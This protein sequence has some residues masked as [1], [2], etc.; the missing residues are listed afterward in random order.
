MSVGP[1]LCAFDGAAQWRNGGVA[2]DASGELDEEV[3]LRSGEM[4][5]GAFAELDAEVL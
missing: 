2:P 1:G 4:A 3:Q 5:F